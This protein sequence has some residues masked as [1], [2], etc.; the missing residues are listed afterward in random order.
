MTQIGRISAPTLT[1]QVNTRLFLACAVIFLVSQIGLT[2]YQDPSVML[3]TTYS[4]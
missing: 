3:R 1:L 2:C 4:D